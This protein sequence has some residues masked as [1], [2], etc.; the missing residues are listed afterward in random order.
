LENIM[1]ELP[2]VEVTRRALSEELTGARI[3]AVVIRTP[4]LRLPVPTELPDLLPGRTLREVGRRGKY[5]LLSCD[6]GCLVIH[7]GMTGHLRVL[8]AATAPGKHDHLDI[9]LSGE[10]VLRF[11]DP[12][13][14]G[15]V[16][17]TTDDPLT[18]PLLADIGPEPLES[19]FDGAYLFD[20]S[21][22]RS[23]AVKQLIMDSS[24]VAGVG[25]IYANEALF[26]SGIRPSRPAKSLNRDEC[27]VLA[28]TIR[29]VLAES[30]VQGSTIMDFRVAEEPLR[31]HP[32][33]FRVYGRGGK[34]C[35]GCG[36]MLEEIRLGNRS[37][38]FCPDC[39]R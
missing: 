30:I 33:A 21:R 9:V 39:Q 26:R 8:P 31:Y 25:N 12:R 10:R 24:V 22:S 5:L 11:N 3:V 4:K 34:H 35:F 29:E 19:G 2:E 18:H 14:F 37:T 13:K 36:G 27:G 17:W 16:L 20:L 15:S 7:L 6:D 32:L 38:V 23:V 28:A 1:P